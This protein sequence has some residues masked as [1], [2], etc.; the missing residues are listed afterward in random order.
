VGT[1]LVA[2]TFVAGHVF[3]LWRR[4]RIGDFWISAR[5]ERLAPALIL[6]GAFAVLLGA[7]ALLGAPEDL[8]LTTLSMGLGTATVAAVTSVWKASAH[9]TVA[10]HATAAGLLVAIYAIVAYNYFVAKVNSFGVQ[11]K[12]FA[13]EFLFALGDLGKVKPTPSEAPTPAAPAGP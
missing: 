9:S 5:A 6:L 1:E 7:L 4:R 10:G 11:Y 13:E 2:A 12:L 3:L 8:L